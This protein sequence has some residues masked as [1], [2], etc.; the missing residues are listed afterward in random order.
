MNYRHRRGLYQFLINRLRLTRGA[1]AAIT[2]GLAYAT[3]PGAAARRRKAAASLGNRARDIAVPEA[4]G[5]R[6][7]APGALPGT[8]AV[9]AACRRIFDK[10]RASGALDARVEDAAKRFL[11]RVERG[12]PLL[13]EPAIRDFVLSQPVL[14][15]AARYFGRMPILSELALLWTPVNES[16]IKSQ[17]YHFDT[18]DDRQ[19]KLFIYITDVEADCGPITLVPA[20]RSAEVSRMTG[21]VGGRRRRLKDAAVAE[22]GAERDAVRILGPAG[23]AVFMDTSRCLHYGSRGNRR[24]RLV[25]LIQFMDYYAPKLEPTDWRAAASP[26]AG[27]LDEARRLLLRC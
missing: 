25:L 24:E 14:S 9:V 20:A 16:Q 1:T 10:A 13:S 27:G 5:H 3:E 12:K 22:A 21:Y 23:T 6:V 18:E 7:L 17:E 19:L 15:A 11:V 26:F 8:E 4:A 2:K